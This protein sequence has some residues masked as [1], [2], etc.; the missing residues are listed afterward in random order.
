ME[1]TVGVLFDY[2]DEEAYLYALERLTACLKHEV[3]TRIIKHE[4]PPINSR[5]RICIDFKIHYNVE[6]TPTKE[7]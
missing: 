2:H 7:D 4:R 1:R 6:Q 3:G 5:Y